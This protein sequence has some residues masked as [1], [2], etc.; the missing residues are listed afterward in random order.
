MYS[1]W[2][3]LYQSLLC[4]KTEFNRLCQLKNQYSL[5]VLAYF[6]GMYIILLW[7]HE[8]LRIV[9]ECHNSSGNGYVG[10]LIME[11]LPIGMY[12]CM[13]NIVTLTRHYYGEFLYRRYL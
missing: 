8:W 3:L 10:Y 2:T 5:S 4:E 7:M 9:I 11:Y 13:T 1:M 12:V 6:R